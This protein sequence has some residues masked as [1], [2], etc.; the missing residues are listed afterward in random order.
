[1]LS[2]KLINYSLCMFFVFLSCKGLA[3]PSLQGI[4]LHR[5]LG[6]DQFL[7]ALYSDTASDDVE[8]ILDPRIAKRMELKVIARDGIVAGRF[9]RMWIEGAA[10]NN[11]IENARRQ[12]HRAQSL[13][14]PYAWR[15]ADPESPRHHRSL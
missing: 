1:M 11:S 7:G 13:L 14:I 2:R 8:V 4:A 3:E 12:C 6:Q 10:I 9:S 15:C 5:E